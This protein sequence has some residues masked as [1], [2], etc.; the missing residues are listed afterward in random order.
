MRLF[1]FF[2]R[3]SLVISKLKRD[4]HMKI[5]NSLLLAAAP[6]ALLATFANSTKSPKLNTISCPRSRISFFAVKDSALQ[7]LLTSQCNSI[8]SSWMK[9]APGSVLLSLPLANIAAF[10]CLWEVLTAPPGLKPQWKEFSTP[11]SQNSKSTWMTWV[12]SIMIGLLIS[13]FFEKSF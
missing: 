13:Q 11:F 10:A 6:F 3:F 1:L 12:Y 8:P 9:Q 7:P 2:K 5:V 4:K